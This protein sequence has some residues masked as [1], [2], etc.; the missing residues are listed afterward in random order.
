MDLVA[1]DDALKVLATVVERKSRVIELRFF[2][3]LSYAR[4]YADDAAGTVNSS[5]KTMLT[6]VVE[7]CR[8]RLAS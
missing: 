2:G 1:L 5:T 3:G 6:F 8:M 4:P 7:A